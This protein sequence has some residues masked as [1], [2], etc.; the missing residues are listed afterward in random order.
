MLLFKL[1]LRA[2]MFLSIAPVIIFRFFF[3][4]M[5]I[6]SLGCKRTSK[7]SHSYA[8]ASEILYIMSSASFA[9]EVM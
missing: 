6:I 8:M 3:F 7:K 2:N 4:K 1:H 9:S 5:P